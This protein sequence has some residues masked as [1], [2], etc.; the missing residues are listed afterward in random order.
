[1][2]SRHSSSD[3]SLHC[4]GE[5]V[6]L[7]HRGMAQSGAVQ[8]RPKLQ[9]RS[10]LLSES[11]VTLHRGVILGLKHLRSPCLVLKTVIQISGFLRVNGDK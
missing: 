11:S 3:S 4:E 7:A 6:L 1:M 10:C 5:S 8:V 9:G 2:Q